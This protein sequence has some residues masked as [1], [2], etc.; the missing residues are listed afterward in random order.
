MVWPNNDHSFDTGVHRRYTAKEKER[1]MLRT[2]VDVVPVRNVR[3][4]NGIR[5]L[6]DEHTILTTN[7]TDAR[8]LWTYTDVPTHGSN[9]TIIRIYVF[10]KN[11]RNF[12]TQSP[13]RTKTAIRFLWWFTSCFLNRVTIWN[14]KRKLTPRE[15]KNFH[16]VNGG[17][18][19][20]SVHPLASTPVR[21]VR[22]MGDGD[23]LPHRILPPPPRPR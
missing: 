21:F 22:C 6:G 5:G 11:R 2:A 15:K 23:F 4:L 17:F 19:V 10:S 8:N 1:S 16:L 13:N 9:A 3:L 7:D 14:W 12:C 18:Q 20:L